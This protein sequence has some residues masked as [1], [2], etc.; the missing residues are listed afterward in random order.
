VFTRYTRFIRALSINWIG[1]LGV[2]L[3]T[4]SFVTFVFFLAAEFAGLVTNA[5]AGLVSFL[6]LPVLFIVG[7]I[8]V[9]IGW[10]RR[11]KETG[12]TTRELIDE[13]FASDETTRGFFGSRVFLG[14]AFLTVV[15]VVFL[16][17]VSSRML[18]FMDESH[19][20]GTACH[21]VMNPEWVT[22]QESP[23]ARVKCVE[24]HVGEGVG[25]LIDSKI[26]GLYQIAS[27]TFD[28]L[29][30]PIP[31]PVKNLRPSRETCEKCHWPQK[32]YGRRLKTIAR[33]AKDIESTPGYNTLSLKVDAGHGGERRGIHWHIA[34]ENEVRYASVRDERR[35]MI[36]VD[37]RQADGSYKRYSNRR[38]AAAGDAAE[39]RVLD[40]VDCHNR[41]THIYENPEDAVDER[42]ELR[43]IDRSLPFVKREAIAALTARYPNEEAA[44]RGI[45]NRLRGFYEREFPEVADAKKEA[46]DAAIAVLQGVYRRNIHHQMNIT[47]GTYK[48][49][50]GHEGETGCFRCHNPKITDDAGN[51]IS[52]DCTLCHSILAYGS[53]EPFA[54][55]QTPRPGTPDYGMH[56]YLRNEFLRSSSK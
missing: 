12:K 23:H 31:T 20:C 10:H 37:V 19:F 32:F 45:A 53:P 4:A 44:V 30:R 38:L 55:V 2:V 50:V 8:L 56:E 5:Y 22:Y 40:C 3:T 14:I 21:E 26:N 11:K 13:R 1:R 51:G 27:V 17:I 48:S 28:L 33:Y 7:L 36:W 54:F 47:W 46:I 18:V 49:L 42:I 43:L 52:G 41:A 25:A 39:E 29:E 24:C 15:N 16:G 6:V 34:E 35:E 9:P